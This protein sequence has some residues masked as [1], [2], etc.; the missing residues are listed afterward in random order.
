MAKL[1]H[2]APVNS[3]SIARD[4]VLI[5]TTGALLLVLNHLVADANE[6]L[7]GSFK[8]KKALV[9]HF[10]DAAQEAVA[11]GVVAT[12]P[13]AADV[14]GSCACRA[15]A[16]ALPAA[17]DSGAADAREPEQPASSDSLA[18]PAEMRSCSM[19]SSHI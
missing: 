17:T 4:R 1:G 9:K 8:V 2:S 16:D 6:P 12:Q 7:N 10:I 11:C 15:M 19:V 14:S 18:S 3:G 5:G 13:A